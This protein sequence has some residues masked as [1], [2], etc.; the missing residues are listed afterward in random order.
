MASDANHADCREVVSLVKTVLEKVW[1]LPVACGCADT[2]G[3]CQGHF[4]GPGI[5]CMGFCIAVGQ[6][7]G[8]IRGRLKRSARALCNYLGVWPY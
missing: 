5:R 2:N 7:V 6:G 8:G 1:D 3:E 4:S